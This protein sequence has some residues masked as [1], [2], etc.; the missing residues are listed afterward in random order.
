MLRRAAFAAAA[1]LTSVL[2]LPAAAAEIHVGLAAPATGRMASAGLAMRRALEAAVEEAN[3]AGGLLGQRLVLETADDGCAAGV[4]EGAAST[5]ASL[6]AAVV[7]GHPCSGA[8]T[9]AAPVYSKAGVPLIAVGARHADVTDRHPSALEKT[10]GKAAVQVIPVPARSAD[11]GETAA[12]LD[13]SGAEAVLFAGFPEEGAI[14]LSALAARGAAIAFLGS[15]AL[16]A[17]MFADAAIKAQ[18]PAQV[19]VPTQPGPASEGSVANRLALEARGGFEAW[20][21]T[22]MRIGSIDGVRVAEALRRDDVVTAS[23]GAIRFDENGDLV[24]EDFVA[25][26]ARDGTWVRPSR[27]RPTQP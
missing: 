16:A 9:A 24:G 19:L 3:A 25:A 7:I 23:L 12:R 8:A 21:A 14:L 13:A 22:A 26:V 15:D 5:L 18:P 4:A 10:E 27:D 1:F 17:P 11:F 6:K 20:L 2:A